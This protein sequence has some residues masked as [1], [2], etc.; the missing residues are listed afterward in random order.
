MN[1]S[2]PNL[3]QSFGLFGLYILITLL[4]GLILAS[5]SS[6]VSNSVIALLGTVISMVLIIVI[7]LNFKKAKYDYLL[8]ERSPARPTAYGIAALFTVF[9]ILV[10]DPLTSA[11]PMPDFMKELFEKV[12]SNDIYSFLA[13]AIAAPILE[14][15][16]FR[17][18]MLEGLE[19]NYGARKAIL[20]SAILFAIFHMNPWQGIG[21]FVIGIFLGWIY[22]KTRDIWLC[23][24][25]HFFNNALSFLA[26]IVF[27]DPFYSMQDLT[28]GNYYTLAAIM[29]ISL[30]ALYVCYKILKRHFQLW[31][32][33]P[34]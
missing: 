22:V 5:V 25:V 2:Y 21:A 7:A 16:L 6:Y 12:I 28:G 31:G 23:I 32:K 27:D 26:F 11:I 34:V 3:K 17:K 14:E 1:R 9:L 4:I 33:E 15:L 20:W 30:I 10:L 19:V 18:I 29:G 24:F 13:I 8:A